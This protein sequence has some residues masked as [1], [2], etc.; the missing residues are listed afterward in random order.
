LEQVP[1]SVHTALS[2]INRN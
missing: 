2:P 1:R